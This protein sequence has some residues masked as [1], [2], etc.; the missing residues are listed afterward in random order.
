MIQHSKLA[1]VSYWQFMDGVCSASQDL[2]LI[3]YSTKLIVFTGLVCLELSLKVD[4]RGGADGHS[5]CGFVVGI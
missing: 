2:V 5:G 1:A 4:V 3:F